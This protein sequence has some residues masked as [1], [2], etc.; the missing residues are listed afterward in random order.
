MP[1]MRVIPPGLDFSMLK[2][3]LHA[4]PHPLRRLCA[5]RCR[6]LLGQAARRPRHGSRRVAGA[7]MHDDGQLVSTLLLA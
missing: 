3:R 5:W 2:V 6:P 4:R 1:Y 7:R